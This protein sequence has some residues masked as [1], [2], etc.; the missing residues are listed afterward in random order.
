MTDGPIDNFQDGQHGFLS[1][2][3]PRRFTLQ[4][5]SGVKWEVLTVEHAFQAWKTADSGWVQH[6]LGASTPSAAKARGRKCP[7]RPEWEQIKVQVMEA[8]VWE[9]FAQNPALAEKLLATGDARLIEGNNWGDRFWGIHKGEGENHLGRILEHVRARLA[10]EQPAPQE[11]LC[12]CCGRT[13]SHRNGAWINEFKPIGGSIWCDAAVYK[14]WPEVPGW[15]D[16]V[17]LPGEEGEALNLL[18]PAVPPPPPANPLGSEPIQPAEPEPLQ[19]ITRAPNGWTRVR[20]WGLDL[21]LPPLVKAKEGITLLGSGFDDWTVKRA[22]HK[23]AAGFSL[24]KKVEQSCPTCGRRVVSDARG[25]NQTM[26]QCLITI[27]RAWCHEAE[28]TFGTVGTDLSR[29]PQD[30]PWIRTDKAGPNLQPFGINNHDTGRDWPQLKYH[31]MLEERP[32]DEDDSDAFKGSA[33][34]R[35]TRHG[36]LFAEGR[37]SVPSKLTTFN[38][39]LA[40]GPWLE[41][42]CGAWNMVTIRDLKG[43]HYGEFIRGEDG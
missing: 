14:H 37:I 11:A 7:L 21:L 4:F 34:W 17:L 12:V 9:K 30:G 3:Y 16:P 26:A 36:M 19:G 8:C 41:D 25:I 23:L 2:F 13:I 20:G 42:V 33:H 40:V 43:F 24:K 10:W 15:E 31:G 18:E 27:C 22:R 38:D 6:I 39:T 29:W 35:P 1:N 32:K 5:S 28:L